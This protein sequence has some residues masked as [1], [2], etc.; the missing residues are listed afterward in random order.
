VPDVKTSWD[1]ETFIENVGK[2]LNPAY[3]WQQQGY[4]DL[5]GA[6]EGEVSYCLVNTPDSLIEEE[7]MRL[8]RKM[9]AVTTES[10]EYKVAVQKL[11]NN[12]TFD[13]MPVLERRLK[14]S[15]KRDDNAIQT[16][17]DTVPKCRDYLFE[18]QE[19]H[20]LGFFTDNEL[21]ILDSLDEI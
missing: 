16:I 12:M 8:Q 5:T 14:F 6:K 3:W 20:L 15:V 7:K 4:F 10:P 2:P 11:I 21:P 17:H 19:M 9:D 1:F 13:D 18:L